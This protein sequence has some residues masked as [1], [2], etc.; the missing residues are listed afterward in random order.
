MSTWGCWIQPGTHSGRLPRKRLPA[1]C[2][3]SSV[4]SSRTS[5][6]PRRTPS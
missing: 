1:G 5:T 2:A 6:A 3:S 4:A